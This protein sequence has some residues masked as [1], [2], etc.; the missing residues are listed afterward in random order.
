MQALE[1]TGFTETGRF[2]VHG[3]SGVDV[4]YDGTQAVVNNFG[5]ASAFRLTASGWVEDGFLTTFGGVGDGDHRHVAISRDGKIA[6]VGSTTDTAAGLGPIF[7]PYQTADD[8]SGGVIV[9]ERKSSGWVIRRLVKPGST[10]NQSAGHTVALGANGNVLA[11]GAPYDS[12]AATGIDG[13]R[14][15][16]SAPQRG[17]VWLY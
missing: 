13:E 8:P 14:D 4:S 7:E 5:A 12:S 15:D 9:H 16:D 17:A 10:N 3:T 11:V 6:A 1:T 2:S